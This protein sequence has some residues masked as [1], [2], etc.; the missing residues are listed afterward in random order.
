[1]SERIATVV[2]VTGK[3]YARNAEGLSRPLEAGDV[4]REGET[5]VTSPGGRVEL[6]LGNG[7]VVHILPEQSVLISAEMSAEMA[8]SA[9]EAAVT[10]DAVDRVVQALES[11]RDPF[12]ELEAPA[13]GLAGGGA[14]DGNDFVRLLRITEE[15]DPLALQ[16]DQAATI[17][18]PTIVGATGNQAPLV[19]DDS[20][21][22]EPGRTVEIDVLANDSDPDGDPLAIVAVA[23]EPIS[24]DEPVTLPEGVV[25]LNPDGTLSFAPNAGFEGE[26]SFEYTVSDGNSLASGQVSVTVDAA[27]ADSQ[28]L[29]V[30]DSATTTVGTSVSGN[31]AAND[32]PSLDGGNVWA[33]VDAPDNG[34]VIVNAD[35][36]YTYTPGTGFTGEDR[37]SYSITDADGDVSIAEVTVTVVD[38]SSPPPADDAPVAVDD[39]VA[40]E[41]DEIAFG[42]LAD[43]DTPSDD[44]GNVWA[45]QTPPENGTAVVDADG[46]FRYTPDAGFSGRDSFTYTVTDIDGD[47]STATVFIAVGV[48]DSVPIAQDDE[49]TVQTGTTFEGDLAEN[50]TPSADGGNVWAISQLAG[51]GEVVVNADGTNLEAVG[52]GVM[53]SWSP[54]GNRIAFSHLSPSGVAIMH[55]DGTHLEMIEEG[56]WGAQWSPD[57]KKIAYTVRSGNRA[58]IRVYD[59]IEGTKT[60]LLSEGESP[61]STIY[62]NMAWSPD[63]NWV[64]FKGRNVDQGTYEIATLNVAG[65]QQGYKV[66]YSNKTAPYADIAWHPSGEKIVFAAG[67]Q[68]R[69]L[70]QFNPAEDKPPAPIDIK[71][72]G[73]IIGDVCFTPD[74]QSLLFNVSGTEE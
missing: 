56:G 11:G 46:S 44:G 1:M 13:A 35:G 12:D 20:T 19:V 4:L 36:T 16:F 65:K 42:N 26:L 74:G 28:P 58:N 9:D 10:A 61:Y 2:A 55:A 47:V 63:S 62:W 29:A 54:Q 33:L 14:G 57:G 18:D 48:A 43:N 17:E 8:A 64:C 37:F 24:V 7:E 38:G 59:L 49:F 52:S 39:S 22:T 66:H 71:V 3:A 21:S 69:Q 23:G 5:V 27:A 15:V 67:S 34:S 30:D 40:I 45:L 6:A 32:S 50:D 72:N 68:P 31:L 60:N 73:T 70:M 41:V 25:S 51:G 53:P